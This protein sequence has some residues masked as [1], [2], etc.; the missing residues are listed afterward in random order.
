[1]AHNYLCSNRKQD[2]KI[3]DCVVSTITDLPE[4]R[5]GAPDQFPLTVIEFERRW[6]VCNVQCLSEPTAGF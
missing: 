2:A 4:P 3:M 6:S 5:S 1:M